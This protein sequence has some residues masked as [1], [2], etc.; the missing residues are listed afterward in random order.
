MPGAT[1]SA[2]LD[3]SLAADPTPAAIAAAMARAEHEKGRPVVARAGR[4]VAMLVP[5]EDVEAL[6][7]L[8]DA[9][10]GRARTAPNV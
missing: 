10:V 7:A 5:I 2:V 4:P 6:D 1:M 9:R 8:E 3:P